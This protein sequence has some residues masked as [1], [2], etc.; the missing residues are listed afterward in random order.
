MGL[1]HGVFHEPHEPDPQKRFKALVCVEARRV[2][3]GNA[4][5][6]IHD[7]RGL[8]PAL[9]SGRG[10]LERRPDAGTSFPAC[11]AARGLPQNGVGD[12]SRFW[13]DPLRRR[14]VGD[15]KFVLGRQEPLPGHHGEFDDLVHW[16][17]ATP[18]FYARVA[19]TTRSTD[20][21]VS[22]TRACTSACA[23]ST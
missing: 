2:R 22:S 1:M 7:S 10:S 4:D 3:D 19:R 5:Q 6:G 15:V 18:T 9:V 20:I 17:Q 14:Y 11:Y 13:W 16:S 23:G 8:L 12:T 21:V